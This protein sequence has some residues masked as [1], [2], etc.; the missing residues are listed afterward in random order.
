ME[1]IRIEKQSGR[2][3]ERSREALKA[4]IE[5]LEDGYA[6]IYATQKKRRYAPTRYR[7]YFG[8]IVPIV[9]RDAGHMFCIMQKGEKRYPQTPEQMHEILK[10]I[11]NPEV[12]ISPKGAFQRGVTT[13]KRD[14]PEFAELLNTIISELSAQPYFCE[15]EKT[16][17]EWKAEISDKNFPI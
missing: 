2:L 17:E 9:L 14:D 16:F 6:E 15:F 4:L 8:Y 1:V 13:T 10:A 7:Y 5:G 12:V 3:T 11:Y